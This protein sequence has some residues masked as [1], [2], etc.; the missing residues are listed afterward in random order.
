ME[1]E[2]VS[3]LNDYVFKLVF[4]DQKNIKNLESLLKT[5]LD[6]PHEEY[7]GLTIVDPFLKRLWKNDKMGILD[8]KVLTRSKKVINVELQIEFLSVMRK[9]VVYYLAKL[10]AEQ[11]KSGFDHG[12]IQE[13]I[14]I[15]ICNHSLGF[16]SPDYLNTWTMNNK[17]DGEQFTDLMKIVTIELSKLPKEDDGKAVWPF[18]QCFKC[19]RKE[20]FDMLA[21]KHP[22][23]KEIAVQVKKLSF[24]ERHRMIA[25]KKAMWRADLRAMMTDAR[26]SG[27]SAGR[28]EGLSKGIEKG[29]AEREQLRLENQK[30]EQENERLREEIA[31]LRS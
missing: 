9:R 24:F 31:R 26:E 18:L 23:V 15:V 25:E 27:L 5:I 30:K 22:E 29:S 10:I 17:K 1:N 20:D 4:G 2:L 21:K 6:L 14:C 19:K 13:T 7:A 8:V 16:A 11:L 3:L 28:E 12:K